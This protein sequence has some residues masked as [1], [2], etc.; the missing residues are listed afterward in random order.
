MKPE[1]PLIHGCDRVSTHHRM[2][3]EPVSFITVNGKMIPED[4]ISSQQ[5]HPLDKHTIGWFYTIKGDIC[6]M[7]KASD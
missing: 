7:S 1:I 3:I 5:R 2:A 6:S 4:N